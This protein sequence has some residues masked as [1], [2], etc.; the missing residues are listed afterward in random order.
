MK[1]IFLK[2]YLAAVL[3][4]AAVLFCAIIAHGA[5]RTTV[6]T[7]GAVVPNP[8]N[9]GI[10]PAVS[11]APA[12]VFGTSTPAPAGSL[13]CTESVCPVPTLVKSDAGA[14]VNPI[15]A[16]VTKLT[17]DAATYAATAGSLAQAQ[18]VLVSAQAAVSTLTQATS[19]AQTL[20][21]ADQAA[22]TAILNPPPPPGPPTPPP[23]PVPSTSLE[24]V[25]VGQVNCPA[26]NA[27]SATLDALKSQGAPVRR[28]NVDAYDHT[29]AFE[30]LSYGVPEYPTF[31]ILDNK[32]ELGRNKQGD[33]PRLTAAS[34]K[35]WLDDWAA[36]LK[37]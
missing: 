4:L 17:T 23:T 24:I 16:A 9:T 3:A 32:K 36:Y 28:V 22:I 10:L 30:A 8:M 35:T 21:A 15:I 37:K 2:S 25:E 34:L 19:A 31:L 18:A 27:Q 7:A 14:P 1:P 5:D 20:I 29:E 11:A 12:L 26:C 6:T 13:V 33:G